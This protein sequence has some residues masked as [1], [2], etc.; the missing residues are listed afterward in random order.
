MVFS[1]KLPDLANNLPM[2][3]FSSLLLHFGT[4]SIHLVSTFAL[5]LTMASFSLNLA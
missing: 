3:W 5:V 4:N 1:S 2:A